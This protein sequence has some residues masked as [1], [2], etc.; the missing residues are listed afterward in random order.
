MNDR[1]FPVTMILELLLVTIMSSCSSGDSTDEPMEIDVVPTNLRWSIKIVGS[2][3][4]N[5]NGDGSG[6]VLINASATNAVRYGFK[7]GNEEEQES[8]TGVLEHIFTQSGINDYNIR[9]FAYSSSGNKISISQMVTVF[10]ANG[11]EQEQDSG[12][13]WS[14]EFDV[15]GAVDSSNWFSE[16]VPPNNGSWFN[17]EQQH[18]TNRMDNAYVSNGT[19]KIVAKKE[20]YTAFNSTKT[21]FDT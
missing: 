4:N 2:G 8:T 21:G 13:V 1:I 20:I 10:V 3:T 19:L 18:Y 15:D 17:G 11:E 6:T 14:D 16:V 12:L 5:P 9:V 7:F